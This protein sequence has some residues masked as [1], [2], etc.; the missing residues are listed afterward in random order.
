MDTPG[1]SPELAELIGKLQS[2]K[3]FVAYGELLVEV[4]R[5]VDLLAERH[6]RITNPTAVTQFQLGNEFPT[7][8]RDY[9]AILFDDRKDC[10]AKLVRLLALEQHKEGN[11]P[12]AGDVLNM[13]L[14][15]QMLQRIHHVED[16]ARADMKTLLAGPVGTADEL[17]RTTHCQLLDRGVAMLPE[18]VVTGGEVG[19]YAIEKTLD[20]QG[21]IPHYDR[22][23]GAARDFLADPRVR[24]AIVAQSGGNVFYT[25]MIAAGITRNFADFLQLLDDV[26]AA[27]AT[28]VVDTNYRGFV[29]NTCM[30]EANAGLTPAAALRQVLARAHVVLGGREDLRQYFPGMRKSDPAVEAENYLRT[31]EVAAPEGTLLVL[32]ADHDGAYVQ[33]P[34]EADI[35]HEPAREVPADEII[36]TTGAG[37]SWNAEFLRSLRAGQPVGSAI[38][39]ACH[40][41][42]GVI[43]VPGAVM[44]EAAL[45]DWVRAEAT[46]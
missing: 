31:M 37:D 25:S 36:D 35:R 34:G 38:Q 7:R 15:V 1:A 2:A 30:A 46:A 16:A 19:V 33:V 10:V 6:P 21:N 20:G 13:L 11:L 14:Y 40:T 45:R 3:Q 9:N 24:G 4:Q 44:D 5:L 22:R 17:G 39:R 28:I 27:G 29:L 23:H 41:A 12:L 18:S 43:R 42:A 8:E 26:K 32:K